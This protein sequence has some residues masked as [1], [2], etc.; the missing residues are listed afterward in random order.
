[1]RIVFVHM[2][3]LC[4]SDC[5]KRF[6]LSSHPLRRWTDS[7]SINIDSNRA[8]IHNRRLS[9]PLAVVPLYRTQNRVQSRPLPS[10][11]RFKMD[12]LC[13]F[14]RSSSAH[15]GKIVLSHRR[16]GLLRSMRLHCHTI[17]NSM[18]RIT[19]LR[20][21]PCRNQVFPRCNSKFVFF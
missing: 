18:T 14:L 6:S 2:D 15:M 8:A 20:V 9:V 5:Q 21:R 4:A 16:L 3:A 19:F 10:Y 1:M 13:H 17:N 11:H 12:N 7:I